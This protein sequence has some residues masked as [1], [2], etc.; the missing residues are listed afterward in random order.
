M[1]YQTDNK[2]D[3]VKFTWWEKLRL[4]RHKGYNF[5][6]FPKRYRDEMQVLN[7]FGIT[8]RVCAMAYKVPAQIVTKAY[9]RAGF[10]CELEQDSDAYDVTM[11]WETKDIP[12]QVYPAFD[13][14]IAT[15]KV[16]EIQQK[17]TEVNA[18]IRDATAEGKYY[19]SVQFDNIYIA[20]RVMNIYQQTDGALGAKYNIEQNGSGLI[21]EWANVFDKE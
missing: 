3:R 4:R 10:K 18:A 21:F 14:M 13:A 16:C 7:N 20:E 2:L 9:S 17:M 8:K 5:A 15:D 1:K 19:V 11:E 6:G 12:V